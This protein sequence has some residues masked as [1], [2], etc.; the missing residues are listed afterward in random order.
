MSASLRRLGQDLV[1]L[2]SPHLELLADRRE[3]L[4]PLLLERENLA[5]DLDWSGAPRAFATRLVALCLSRSHAEQGPDLLDELLASLSEE[6]VGLDPERQ[7]TLAAL[8]ERLAAL[9]PEELPAAPATRRRRHWALAVAGAVA[10]VAAMAFG[11]PYWRAC[12]RP[13][14]GILRV[15]VASFGHGSGEH[16]SRRS[17]SAH[18][19]A[20]QV[21][22]VLDVELGTLLP[23]SEGGDELG[24][25]DQR[26]AV[27]GPSLLCPVTGGDA[28]AR[29][30]K[31]ARLAERIGADIL[32]YGTL[33]VS[34]GGDGI[35]STR[36]APS[37]HVTDDPRRLR[38]ATEFAGSHELGRPIED[39]DTITGG[40]ALA[41]AIRI[42]TGLLASF[43]VALSYFADGQYRDAEALL[44]GVAEDPDWP[45][46][47]GKEVVHLFLGTVV[48]QD[49][50]RR[51]RLEEAAKWFERALDLDPEYARA[52]L[53]RAEVLFQQ[54]ID[55]G[56][57]VIG[58]P[59]VRD[60]LERAALA[61]DA[62]KTAAHQPPLSQ[63]V[64]KADFGAGRVRFCQAAEGDLGSWEEVAA[65]FAEVLAAYDAAEGLEKRH[66]RGWAT[67]AAA[68]LGLV[69]RQTE[70]EA[71]GAG[72]T[73]AATA[74]RR[75][76]L[77]HFDR[78]IEIGD[79]H[80][81][82]AV[83][84]LHRTELLLDL[85]D[86]PA[87]ESALRAAEQAEARAHAEEESVGG[88]YEQFMARVAPRVADGQL[89][90]SCTDASYP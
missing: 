3:W 69:A 31:A 37:F 13:I 67:E 58:P 4:R 47:E 12:H 90:P 59:S 8:R 42:R 88:G 2:L 21:A 11:I 85:C 26:I 87:A 18:R 66:L 5:G 52:Q 28:D 76:A 83:F 63:A 40:G 70:T 14:D 60:E 41:E 16:R 56:A 77:A 65:P 38:D 39:P 45:E 1:E 30:A 33:E 17:L 46:V 74:A 62:A 78:A 22:E 86:L 48:L 57:C 80:A 72:D 29:A 84:H 81:R 36:L 53:G 25:A 89:G 49:L 75:A 32:V 24:L 50:N 35:E 54:A 82:A 23:A 10:L 9:D 27:R 44:R 51:T 55:R 64:I 15:A 6:A 71:I 79:L 43:V 19:M 34:D 7:A 20:R 68:M 61:F 73:A